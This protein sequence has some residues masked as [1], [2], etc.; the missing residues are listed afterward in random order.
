MVT[1]AP[2][3]KTPSS[4]IALSVVLLNCLGSCGVLPNAAQCCRRCSPRF[5]HVL[6]QLWCMA[7][8]KAH[9]S[10]PIQ[11]CVLLCVVVGPPLLQPSWSNGS[12]PGAMLYHHAIWSL[13]HG[14]LKRTEMK[15]CCSLYSVVLW[16]CAT[17]EA[18][19]ITQLHSLLK[20]LRCV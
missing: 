5:I 12:K 6:Q 16:N 4:R 11:S 20:T 15:R 3:C 14:C 2:Y 10:R 19:H 1:R 17:W 7:S 13:L 9:L 18:E 8:N